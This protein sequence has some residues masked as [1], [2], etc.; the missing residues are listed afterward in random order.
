MF[1]FDF[2]QDSSS[3][4]VSSLPQV[5]HQVMFCLP[6][7]EVREANINF[8]GAGVASGQLMSGILS[9]GD[10]GAPGRSPGA[11]SDNASTSP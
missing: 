1:Y 2:S 8:R 11:S 4:K 10:A 3:Q 6:K 5:L 7:C 9:S